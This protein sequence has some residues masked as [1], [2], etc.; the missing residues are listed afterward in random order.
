MQELDGSQ[1]KAE[2]LG[3]LQSLQPDECVILLLCDLGGRNVKFSWC[4]YLQFKD[5]Q[6]RASL[7]PSTMESS[8][9]ATFC[10]HFAKM[11]R[12]LLLSIEHGDPWVPMKSVGGPIFLLL[13]SLGRW[14]PV[15]VAFL[16]PMNSKT[17]THISRGQVILTL[18]LPFLGEDCALL[19]EDWQGTFSGHL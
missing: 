18:L 3:L 13:G 9:Y 15:H 14:A 16:W 4:L 19:R 6:I 7:A 2:A 10:P 5:F 8:R 1:E 12:K 17:Q 11:M